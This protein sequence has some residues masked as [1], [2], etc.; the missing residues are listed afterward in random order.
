V[1]VAAVLNLLD[2]LTTW[3]GLSLGG[4][5]ISLGSVQI[6]GLVGLNGY[7][8]LKVALSV[9]LLAAALMVQ[10]RVVPYQGLKARLVEAVCL[11]IFLL[12]DLQYV[13][14]LANNFSQLI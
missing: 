8:L 5:E 9:V 3:V 6:I 10:R 11:V 12:G 2:G 13:L 1:I 7:L 14:V 4:H